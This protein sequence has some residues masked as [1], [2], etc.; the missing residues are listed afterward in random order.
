MSELLHGVC[1]SGTAKGWY[2]R[3][4]GCGHAA[5]IC[6]VPRT[7]RLAACRSQ[8]W[9]IGVTCSCTSSSVEDSGRG[10]GGGVGGC[11]TEELTHSVLYDLAVDD[12]GVAHGL[13]LW[14]LNQTARGK[15]HQGAKSSLAGTSERG[16]KRQVQYSRPG[17]AFERAVWE[18]V[19]GRVVGLEGAGRWWLAVSHAWS[20]KQITWLLFLTLTVSSKCDVA[21]LCGATKHIRGSNGGRGMVKT[22]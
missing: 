16:I 22:I 10:S 21:Q 19:K 15:E 20:H 6:G 17:I 12:T 5:A 18:G 11:A 2:S 14:Q 7:Q 13:R 8:P 4:A 3:G 9:T 1:T